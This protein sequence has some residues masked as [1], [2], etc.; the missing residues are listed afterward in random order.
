[1]AHVL[2]INDIEHL[3]AY[4]SHWRDLLAQTPHANFF[5]TLEWLEVY[6]RHYG[7]E[8]QLR[9][10]MEIEDGELVGIVPL[11]LK[12]ER[13]R[14][15]RIRFLTYPMDS[16]GSFYGPIGSRPQKTLTAALD[17]LRQRK[18]DWDVLELRW[19]GSPNTTEEV[20][21]SAF[22]DAGLPFYRTQ[23]DQISV[24]DM[25]G[26]WSDYFASRPSKYRNN[27]R[28]WG[29]RLAERGEVR[30]ERYRPTGE[31]HGDGD[32]RWDLFEKCV[33]VARKSWQGKVVDG[34]T[35]CHDKVSPFLRDVHQV[36]AEVGAL[37]LNLIYVDE[38][39]V[40]YAY[41]Y[42]LN[43]YVSGLRIGFDEEVR[44]EG[45]GNL[46]YARVIED[47]FSRGDRLYDL[48]PGSLDAKRHI[49]TQLCSLSRLT[50]FP[51][52]S[53]LSVRP[54]LLRLARMAD[55]RNA[56]KQTPATAS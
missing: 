37:D 29:R 25:N 11:T 21:E 43:G 35:L 13:S 30:Y 56:E 18:R 46:L 49:R 51:L 41:N 17:Y 52:G 54:N 33:A 4:R 47:S 36:A 27:M 26:S 22:S 44:R 23:I 12:L 48:G 28:R 8:Q 6:W 9:V 50:N 1:M 39:P 45:V 24:I 38:Q 40:A 32:P 42:H 10:L 53:L 31:Q 15:G 3:A 2:E 5:Q 16:W 19:T 14:A 20:A 7:D 34:T 55:V